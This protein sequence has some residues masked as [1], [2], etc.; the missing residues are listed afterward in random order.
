MSFFQTEKAFY[1]FQICVL[2]L[3][4]DEEQICIQ[5]KR[6]GVTWT[7]F[8]WK[9]YNIQHAEFLHTKANRTAIL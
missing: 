4:L 8:K 3:R 6:Q 5:E 1:S 7:D 9:N 2:K